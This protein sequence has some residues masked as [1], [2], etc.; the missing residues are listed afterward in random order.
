ML[1]YG[2]VYAPIAQEHSIVIIW[3]EFV[4]TRVWCI[5][6]CVIDSEGLVECV[7]PIGALIE[8]SIVWS[9]MVCNGMK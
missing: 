7:R 8:N 6:Y 5:V 9:G 1:K 2:R 3:Y 4:L